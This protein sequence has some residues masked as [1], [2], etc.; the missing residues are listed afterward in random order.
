MKLSTILTISAAMMT[1]GVTWAASDVSNDGGTANQAAASVAAPVAATQTATIIAGS[2][3]GA[4]APAPVVAPA[5]GVA[6]QGPTSRLFDTRQMGRAAG[7]RFAKVGV[8]VE[9]SV[10]AIDKN[11][12]GL[13]MDG[14]VYTLI[15]GADYKFNDRGVVGLAL[16]YDSVDID[17]AFNN[18]TYESNGLTVA[19]YFGYALTPRWSID[20]SGGYTWLDYDTSRNSSAVR[21]SFDAGRWFGSANVNGTYSH[22]RWRFF[23]RLGVLYLSETQDGYTE[24]GAGATVVGEDS[25]DF[26]RLTG[27]LKLGYAFNNVLPYAK[28]MGEW[29]FTTPDSVQ[30][31]NGQFSNV[32]DGGVVLGLGVDVFRGPFTASLEGSYNS[33][34]RDDLDI[35]QGK[36]RLRYDF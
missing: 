26:G 23:P 1:S 34:L 31:A 36:L 29:D 13:S 32:D 4:V 19:P 2:V 24:T 22:N 9:G 20:L 33:G 30:K 6:P 25:F 10:T 27:G 35:Y 11:E 12:T 14:T 21:G 18:G 3:A 7:G 17:T 16:G 15:G 5:P 28:V 8:W